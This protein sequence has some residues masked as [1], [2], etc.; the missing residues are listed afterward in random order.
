MGK[1]GSQPA[2]ECATTTTRGEGREGRGRGGG[3]GVQ[4][5]VT[6]KQKSD[7]VWE[8]E[9]ASLEESTLGTKFKG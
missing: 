2:H 6:V 7:L 3:G 9:M 5:A 8:S 1:R 4:V